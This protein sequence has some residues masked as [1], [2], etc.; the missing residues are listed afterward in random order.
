MAT[1]ILMFC[2]TSNDG[3]AFVVGASGI[4]CWDSAAG[5]I[6]TWSV[7]GATGSGLF[8]SWA[9]ALGSKSMGFG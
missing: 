6:Y 7:E 5:R 2:S 3:V 8:M 9:V 4:L 1:N